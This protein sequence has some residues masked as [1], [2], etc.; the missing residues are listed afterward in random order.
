M[1]SPMPPL[2]LPGKDYMERAK[3]IWE[4]LGLPKLN[5]QKPWHGYSLGAW[6]QVWDEAGL[7]PPRAIIL[8]MDYFS[9]FNPGVE[10]RNQT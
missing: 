10:T 2:A 8:K 1:K 7:L 9:C 6:H 5:V 3:D 4:E